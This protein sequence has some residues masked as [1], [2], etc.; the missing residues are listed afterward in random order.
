MLYSA[1]DKMLD[2]ENEFKDW[3]APKQLK[4][5]KGLIQ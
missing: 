1:T 4:K 5:K 2:V 3:C